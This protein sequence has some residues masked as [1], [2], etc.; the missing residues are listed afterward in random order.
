M[1]LED[2]VTGLP[3]EVVEPGSTEDPFSGKNPQATSAPASEG[4]PQ[5]PVVQSAEGNTEQPTTTQTP[6][7][8]PVV[9][10]VPANQ[11]P[12]TA[13][14]PVAPETETKSPEE[15]TVGGLS[16]EEEEALKTLGSYFEEQTSSSV[17]EALSKQQSN[18]DKQIA[19]MNKTIESIKEQEA[20]RTNQIRE[21]ETRD[22]SEDERKKVMDVYA[23]D[24]KTAQLLAYEQELNEF[25]QELLVFNLMQEFQSFG[26]TQESLLKFD[27]PG[28]MQAYCFEQKAEFLEKKLEESSST[29]QTVTP[30]PVQTPEKPVEQPTPQVPPGA[31]APSDIGSEGATPQPKTFAT[32]QSP[33]A[34]QKNLKDMGWDTVRIKTS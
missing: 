23:Q 24:D 4:A 13:Q 1:E 30:P 8:E 14:E 33:D 6:T 28:E 31:T 22:L 5:E 16:L 20:Q 32:E 2:P 3:V 7:P 12:A 29:Q 11:A 17:Q 19:A 25:H 9:Q 34:F 21:L 18:Y 10:V 26:V 27:N 15:E